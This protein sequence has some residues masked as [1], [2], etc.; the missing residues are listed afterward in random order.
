M[1][2]AGQ[3]ASGYQPIA[4]LENSELL[5]PGMPLTLVGYGRLS[6]TQRGTGERLSVDTKFKNYISEGEFSGLV[7]TGPT[8]NQSACKGDSGGPAYA[9]IDNRWTVIGATQGPDNIFAGTLS[10]NEG[11][12]IWNFIAHYKD[13]LITS[14]G[15]QFSFISDKDTEIPPMQNLNIFS[16]EIQENEI[17]LKNVPHDGNNIRLYLNDETQPILKLPL[18]SNQTKIILD[19]DFLDNLN[20]QV[21]HVVVGNNQYSVLADAELLL[22]SN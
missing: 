9:K 14:T 16:F 15:K 3:I 17:F 4:I 6:D 18:E 13:W 2:F 20:H 7:V 12:G 11:N 21:I 8:P 22:P 5:M 19:L 10:C 1:E